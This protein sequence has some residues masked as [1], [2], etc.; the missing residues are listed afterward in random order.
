MYEDDEEVKK[1]AKESKTNR[2]RWE[3][4]VIRAKKIIYVK[5]NVKFSDMPDYIKLIF[6]EEINFNI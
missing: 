6:T 2:N 3:K 1:Q 5:T 4:D